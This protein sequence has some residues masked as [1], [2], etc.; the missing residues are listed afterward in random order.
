MTMQTITNESTTPQLPRGNADDAA[1][2]GHLSRIQER[3]FA[4]ASM[5]PLFETDAAG[6]WEAYLSAF[7]A[8]ER[9]YHNCGS[10]KR[11]IEVYGGLVTI[12]ADGSTRSAIW[13]DDES[14][15][16]HERNAIA[17]I[18]RAGRAAKVTGPFLSKEST[19]GW[20]PPSEWIHLHVT[21][22]P[23]IV[24]KSNALTA[25]QAMA[26]KREDFKNVRRALGEF[27][28]PMVNQALA[29]LRSEALFR[30]EKVVGAA[31]WLSDLHAAL[32]AA[33][34]HRRDNVLWRFV[35]LAPAGFCHPRSSMIGT[36]L[37]DIAAG[38]S[39]EEA[40]RKFR[41][42]MDPSHYQR[43][44][45]APSAGA[46]QAAEK[47]VEKLG[48]APS[49][50]RRFARLDELQ[51]VWFAKPIDK[52]T[53]AVGVFGHLQPKVVA[54]APSMVAP[55]QNIT[56]EKFARTVLPTTTV[57]EANV[58]AQRASLFA[59]LTAY[60]TEAP[61][62]LQWDAPERRNPFSWYTYQSGSPASQWA[63]TGGWNKV[64][65]ITLQPS[66]WNGGFG[67]QSKGAVL[68]LDGCKD[69][70]TDQGNALFPEILKAELHGA[71]SVIEAYSKTAK[72]EGYLEAS[73]CGLLIP[74][75]HVRV[76]DG[77]GVKTEWRVDRWD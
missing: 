6:L 43:P 64:T 39:F 28:A 21:P 25:G 46:I 30:S 13:S 15:S 11:F 73:A 61:P 69:T 55:A 60:D 36:L 35:A 70:K 10:C 53:E 72:I 31:Q 41:I 58:P 77:H 16:E 7:P 62:I 42:K 9:Q 52:E 1:Y 68:I 44:Q 51:T 17:A 54:P 59:I 74:G 4:L 29:L 34:K 20:T 50:R 12:L 40:A 71:R 67:H 2:V 56:W 5:D 33:P 22:P 27:T 18:L 38:V 66:M 47:L 8:S 24:Y 49:L 75:A 14:L 65:A 45:A 48:I 19:W 23:S 76:T 3:F 26:E 57:I 63:I 37:D 32:D